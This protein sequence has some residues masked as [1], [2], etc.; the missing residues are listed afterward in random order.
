[1]APTNT[2]SEGT[3]YIDGRGIERA[4]ELLKIAEDL[5][6][7]AD[8]IRTTSFGYTVPVAVAQAY[9]AV[10]EDHSVTSHEDDAAS[11]QL[12]GTP[13]TNETGDDATAGEVPSSTPADGEQTEGESAG[14]DATEGEKQPEPPRAGAGSSTQAWSDWA[15]ATHNYN[16][17]EGLT[18]DKLITRYGASS[19][20]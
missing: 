5:G 12:D 3:A 17:E 1:M 11:S 20:E 19:T 9:G 6:L 10:D 15:A 13:V 16:P 14:A 2:P 4:R 7:G 18:R 8:A